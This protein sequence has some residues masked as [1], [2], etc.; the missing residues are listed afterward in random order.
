MFYYF[1]GE[2]KFSATFYQQAHTPLEK[3]KKK[4]TLIFCFVFVLP[5]RKFLRL[6]TCYTPGKIP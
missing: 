6:K 3:L 4:L 2:K 5:Y 1:G